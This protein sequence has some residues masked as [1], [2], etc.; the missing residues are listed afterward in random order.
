LVS[1]PGVGGLALLDY[2][3]TMSSGSE[4]AR[5][6]ICVALA[7]LAA[8]AWLLLAPAAQAQPLAPLPNAPDPNAVP[9]ATSLSGR[10]I[11]RIDVVFERP[12]WAGK[13]TLTRVRV[14]QLFTPE[15]A[16]RALDELA[17]SGRFGELRAEVEPLGRGVLLRLRV[18][19]RRL[20]A[21][22]R[23]NGVS[24]PGELLRA[25][26]I[27]SGAE[28]TAAELP[29]FVTRLEE[30]LARRGYPRALVRAD[31][32]D[33]DDPLETVLAF[34]VTAGA[35]VR[36]VARRF[37]VW[38]DPKAPRLGTLL[39]THRVGRGDLANL[40]V[41][42][43]QSHELEQSLRAAGYF[44]ARVEHELVPGPVG[45]RLDV[46]VY[47]GALVVIAFEGNRRFDE[48]D[49]REALDLAKAS[50][51]SPSVLAERVR[52]YYVARGFFDAEV[53]AILDGREGA[54]LR[55]LTLRINEGE[56]VRVVAREYPCL[57]G[58]HSA[59]EVGSEINSFLSELPGGTLVDAVDTRTVDALFGPKHQ[60]GRRP[61]PLSSNPWSVYSPE[62]YERALEHL[63]DLFRSEGYLSASVG[64]TTVMR[65]ACDVRSPPG[66]CI[67]KTT[68]MQPRFECRH[69]ATG[70]PAPEPP[71]DPAL[72]CRADRARGVY[73]EPEAVLSIP[74]KLGPRAFLSKVEADGNAIVP[75]ETVLAAA[76]L[77]PGAPVSQSELERA[78]RRVLDRYAE[79]GFAF[80]E[81][82]VDLA[83]SADHRRANVRFV[84]SERKPVKVSRIV[85]RGARNTSESVIRRRIALEQ[86]ALYRRSLVRTTEER[87]GALGV[88]SSVTVGFEDPYVPASEKVVIVALQERK[89]QYLDVRPGFSTGEGFRITFEYGHRNLSGQAI[90]LTLRSQLGYLPAALILEDS[91]RTKY[92][93]LDALERLERRNTATVEFPE[94]GLGPLFR[95]RVEGVDVRDNARDWGLTKDA[96][97]LSV[98]FL[99]ERR[100][101][102]ELG[103]SLERNDASIFGEESK[104]SL[105][106]YI[107]NNPNERNAFRV[108]EGPTLVVAERVGVTWDRRDTP[109]DATS[110]TFVSAGI[111]HVNARPINQ[112]CPESRELSVFS[113]ACSRFLRFTNR[114]AGYL[115]LSKRGLALAASMR[116]GLNQQLTD[117]SR[118]Y[119]DR[120]FFLGGVDSLRGFLQE[121]LIPEDVAQELLDNPDLTVNEIVIR[122]GDVFVNPRLELRI[123]LTGGV[124]TALFLDSGNLWVDP[125]QVDLLEL[126]YAVGSGLRVGTPVG[127]LVFD[128]G[129]NVE[130]VLDALE[131]S[132]GRERYWEDIGAF[133]F[134]IGLF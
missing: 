106:E 54:P 93:E 94:I 87:L 75:D 4:R 73:C 90:Q 1:L 37:L 84:I 65:R 35:P 126:R 91:V 80:A 102:L 103:G 11:A 100:L 39:A 9:D 77:T 134:S 76:E 117:R 41:I 114:L 116:W 105:D 68:R 29:R 66:R 7:S 15:V 32:F 25:A 3:A 118:T 49:L 8:L 124:H 18:V 51:R 131:L 61:R 63:Q 16:R 99:P 48:R 13:V 133:H 58:E 97:I 56:L 108:P 38:P 113:P 83:L 69:D 71:V 45:P 20:I 112:G 33:T 64:P 34:D 121:A 52:A 127:P 22:V 21:G 95:L 104:N 30:E 98:F 86:G 42:E 26:G 28:I 79:D 36:I 123:P 6:S 92:E 27:K 19:A 62:V 125:A 24:D 89:P 115:R 122:G 53:D 46:K 55:R 78:R 81:V 17:D 96:G 50:D 111:E 119:P 74:I 44:D 57:S 88:F 70:L 107:E 72:S 60:T 132:S 129:F 10:N 2:D 40:E 101:W 43:T 128:Y 120:L 23:V 67:P 31:T 109:L 5:R 47:A 82:E 14:G 59:D 12:L 110:G 85:V 130:R